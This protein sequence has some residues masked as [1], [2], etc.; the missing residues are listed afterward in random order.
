M[1]AISLYNFPGFVRT[2]THRPICEKKERRHQV[3]KIVILYGAIKDSFA[4]LNELQ[5]SSLVED[6][7]REKKKEKL[8]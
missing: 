6:K 4:E 8:L 1:V 2:T 5:E 3:K 7:F